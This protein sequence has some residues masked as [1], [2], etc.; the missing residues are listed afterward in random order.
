MTSGTIK[1]A[2]TENNQLALKQVPR[3]AAVKGSIVIKNKVAG[4]NYAD[5]HQVSGHFPV[6]PSKIVGLEG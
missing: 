5:L 4:I 3:P 6:P 1:A 2:V